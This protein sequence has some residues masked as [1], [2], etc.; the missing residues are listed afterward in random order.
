MNKLFPLLLLPLC[1]T[2]VAQGGS[3]SMMPDGSRDMYVGMALSASN[4]A[5]T[6]EDRGL[7]PRPLLQVEWSNGIFVSASGV[8]GMNLSPA[9]DVEAGPLLADSN[10]RDPN[11]RRSLRG[12]H[13]IR[14][15]LDAGGY[16]NYYLGDD[17]RLVSSI[18]YDTSAHGVRGELGV[19]KSWRT[20]APHHTL[21]V[22]AGVSL[23]SDAVMRE[24]Y[25]VSRAAGG[26]R[27]Y[28]PSAGVTAFSAG[29]NWNW[30]LSSTWLLTS[31][32][33]ATR[34]GAQAADSPVVERRGFLTVYSGLAYRF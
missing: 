29:A 27:D 30:A 19:Q 31:G 33:T 18:L 2:A 10:A 26:V 12:S 7:R 24:Q 8:A 4:A 5:A 21:S 17:T 14:G 25:E 28:T 20:L 13:A 6:G 23:A 9:V 11:D 22:S 16:F 15:S 32:V 1:G 34:L 3:V